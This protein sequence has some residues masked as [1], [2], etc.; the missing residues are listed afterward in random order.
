MKIV[1]GEPSDVML[2]TPTRDRPVAFRNCEHWMS[3]QDFEGTAFWLVV[4]DGDISVE[5]SMG[6]KLMRRCATAKDG[7][8][9]DNVKIAIPDMFSSGRVVVI[10]DDDWYSPGYVAEAVKRL[11]AGVDLVGTTNSRY[12]NLPSRRYFEHANTEHSS[13]CSTA[14][15]RRAVVELARIADECASSGNQLIDMMLWRKLNLTRDLWNG[16][17]TVCGMKGYP[18]RRNLCPSSRLGDRFPFDPDGRMLAQWIG[19]EDAEYLMAQYK[20]K[21]GAKVWTH[22]EQS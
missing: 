13:F 21:E 5:P 18:G 17:H 4:D 7:T 15:G 22:V 16:K 11:A 1:S 9:P 12:Y 6:Q 19:K 10:E 2:F 14:M 8:L 20:R 3:R